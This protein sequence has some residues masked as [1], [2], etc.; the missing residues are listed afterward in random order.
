MCATYFICFGYCAKEQAVEIAARKARHE[1]E[2]T[3]AKEKS[4]QQFSPSWKGKGESL[5]VGSQLLSLACHTWRLHNGFWFC[6]SPLQCVV[7]PWMRDGNVNLAFYS[8]LSSQG[9]S[10]TSHRR[11]R[12]ESQAESLEVSRKPKEV[13]TG[14]VE[15]HRQS[16]FSFCRLCVLECASHLG[17]N[18][19]VGSYLVLVVIGRVVFCKSVFER[20]ECLYCITST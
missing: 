10:Q 18:W 2:R 20:A 12:V 17:K 15:R 6:I 8:S 13:G 3:N 7:Y 14:E 5:G 4:F 16:V 1:E 9:D 19:G 11:G